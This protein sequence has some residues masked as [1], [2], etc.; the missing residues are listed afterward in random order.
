MNA[1]ENYY[2]TLER[3]SGLMIPLSTIQSTEGPCSLDLARFA[4]FRIATNIATL[5]F[6]VAT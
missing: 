4:L 2:I 3:K 6:L 1:V 5:Y